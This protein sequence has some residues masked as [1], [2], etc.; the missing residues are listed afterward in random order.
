MNN[1]KGKFVGAN[2][3][4]CV[5][6]VFK[7][8]SPKRMNGDLQQETALSCI[9]YLSIEIKVVPFEMTW[10]VPAALDPSHVAELFKKASSDI[11]RSGKILQ[12]GGNNKVDDNNKASTNLTFS[13]LSSPTSR[14]SGDQLLSS[15]VNPLG[16]SGALVELT[17]EDRLRC[18]S[19]LREMAVSV[20]ESLPQISNLPTATTNGSS[21][22]PEISATVTKGINAGKKL[23]KTLAKGS[24]AAGEIPSDAPSSLL[25]F[26]LCGR[27]DC[28][29]EDSSSTVAHVDTPV[30]GGDKSV[31]LTCRQLLEANPDP[32]VHFK[33]LGA[34]LTSAMSMETSLLQEGHSWWRVGD[35]LVICSSS[36]DD[37]NVHDAE[38]EASSGSIS[39]R[40]TTLWRRIFAGFVQGLFLQDI[41]ASAVRALLVHSLR[42]KGLESAL[43]P[44]S[45]ATATLGLLASPV[46][47]K[48]LGMVYKSLGHN[49]LSMFVALP[50]LFLPQAQE[51]HSKLRQAVSTG[52][53]T[54]SLLS[55]V[56]GLTVRR[57][58][59]V[60]CS[61]LYDVI[62]EQRYWSLLEQTTQSLSST[63]H[64]AT[65]EDDPVEILY[66][67]LLGVSTLHNDL[68]AAI[69]VGGADAESGSLNTFRAHIVAPLLESSRFVLK[70]ALSEDSLTDQLLPLVIQCL[71]TVLGC[72]SLVASDVKGSSKG[73]NRHGDAALAA[74]QLVRQELVGPFMQNVT[75]TVVEFTRRSTVFGGGLDVLSFLDDATGDTVDEDGEENTADGAGDSARLPKSLKRQL[76]EKRKVLNAI[77]SSS[78]QH[79]PLTSQTEGGPWGKLFKD[80]PSSSQRRLHGIVPM[81]R[82]ASILLLSR[83]YLPLREILSH[84][85]VGS[86][87]DANAQTSA[88]GQFHRATVF[89]FLFQMLKL[90]EGLKVTEDDKITSLVIAQSCPEDNRDRIAS[91]SVQQRKE[92]VVSAIKL[93]FRQQR[94]N[95]S[96]AAL[97]NLAVTDETLLSICKHVGV[98]AKRLGLNTSVVLKC[99]G[100][101]LSAENL[102]RHIGKELVHL[103]IPGC[104][105][106]ETKCW[107]AYAAD[108]TLY[109]R[110]AS[111][112][113]SSS[114]TPAPAPS[115]PTGKR[116]AAG[117]IGAF[118]R[119]AAGLSSRAAEATST[120]SGPYKAVKS[121]EAL[122]SATGDAF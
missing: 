46:A 103:T 13:L 96:T 36:A 68:I 90:I 119:V 42:M 2:Y 19:M 56:P 18:L 34:F 83:W 44:N 111:D 60:Q 92:E 69:L 101:H 55:S 32:M 122:L 105:S 79:P 112:L 120:A 5:F 121:L 31:A 104:G 106:S 51:V 29:G 39:Q 53:T 66:R 28:S 87:E 118:S 22:V 74:A 49:K 16:I 33:S 76:T 14:S 85:R 26:G 9:H 10:A 102:Q 100:G 61:A 95:A 65:N 71:G 20:K 4:D 15:G 11:T 58:D 75:A 99:M 110:S 3:V 115:A 1:A 77:I 52:R 50:D 67:Q 64:G 113:P 72:T 21:Y 73:V 57:G 48:L 109:A 24:A 6:F 30:D 89:T 47:A 41:R 12:G 78:S 17:T 107:T 116:R 91:M 63:S 84:L 38:E 108:G 70:G 40:A 35:V 97:Q 27:A 81:H 117:G 59:F 80:A 86:D 98:V 43:H 62:L 54:A 7:K 114:P 82:H 25:S 94:E 23:R 88:V 8:I 45:M 37:Q 93:V